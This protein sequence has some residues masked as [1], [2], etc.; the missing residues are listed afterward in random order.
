M[1]RAKR[2]KKELPLRNEDV[3]IL[4]SCREG[5]ENARSLNELSNNEDQLFITNRLGEAAAPAT[6]SRVPC[7]DKL[8]PEISDEDDMRKDQDSSCGSV[9]TLPSIPGSQNF[10]SGAI[11][12]TNDPESLE[13]CKTSD[14]VYNLSGERRV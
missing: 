8:S 1:E 9:V 6:G 4:N 11:L 2:G 13:Y 10:F 7:D 3:L 14:T 5:K 12:R